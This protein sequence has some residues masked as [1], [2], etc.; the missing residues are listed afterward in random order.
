VQQ[1][2]RQSERGGHKRCCRM[3]RVSYQLLFLDKR[4][5]VQMAGRQYGLQSDRRC[6]CVRE[7]V[8]QCNRKCRYKAKIW[9]D[10]FFLRGCINKGMAHTNWNVLQDQT[11][12]RILYTG[13]VDANSHQGI[14][15]VLKYPSCWQKIFHQ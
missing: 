9:W 11:A 8:C 4:G 7:C 2:Q 1:K 5:E 15:G 10:Q 6:G 14:F 12:W 3:N 13:P